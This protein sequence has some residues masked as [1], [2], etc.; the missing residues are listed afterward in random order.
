MRE[1]AEFSTWVA[2]AFGATA[3]AIATSYTSSMLVVVPV[4][5]I[6]AFVGFKA[7]RVGRNLLR[8]YTQKDF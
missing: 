3:L 7:E 2:L 6:A 8:R 1:S 5:A 4:A